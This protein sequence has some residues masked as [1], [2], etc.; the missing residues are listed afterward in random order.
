VI[1]KRY[2]YYIGANEGAYDEL[3]IQHQI[4]LAVSDGSNFGVAE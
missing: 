2:L 1:G 4:E 3:S